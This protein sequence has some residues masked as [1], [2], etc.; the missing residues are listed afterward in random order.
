MATVWDHLSVEEL[1]ERFV[2]CEDATASRH[3]QVI[4]LLARGHTIS[5]VSGTTAYGERWIEQ[6]L[7]RY[8]AEGPEALGDLRRRNGAPA[9]ILKP[10]LLAKLRLRL[11]DPPP[12]GGLWQGCGLDG[13]RTQPHLGR[14]AAGLGSVEGD[15]LVDPEATSEEPEIGH[16]RRS[17]GI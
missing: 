1:E 16:A 5:Q 2:G 7:A 9:T 3:F 14:P 15:R 12:D 6:L 8:N 17:G 11:D 10:D 13:W 4:W